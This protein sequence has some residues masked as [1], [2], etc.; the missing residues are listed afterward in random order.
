M[1]PISETDGFQSC[2]KLRAITGERYTWWRAKTWNGEHRLH[3]TSRVFQPNIK[4]L[5]IAPSGTQRVRTWICCVPRDR[6]GQLK[7][8]GRSPGHRDP[9]ASPY[10]LE[11]GETRSCVTGPKVVTG[12]TERT[13]E[14]V[15]NQ[16][17]VLSTHMSPRTK[18]WTVYEPHAVN[19]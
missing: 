14:S 12:Y 3:I 13:A 8:S 15:F 17:N 18:A 6:S 1:P 9:L 5:T 16:K 11:E 10:P 7:Q 4:H 2:V 19:Q